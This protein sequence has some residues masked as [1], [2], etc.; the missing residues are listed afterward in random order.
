M[1]K[2]ILLAGL[3][4]LSQPAMAA[5]P[6]RFWNTT[7]ET[8]KTL[9]MAPAGTTAYGP[10]QCA[11]DDDN[12]VDHNERLVLKGITPGRYDVKLGYKNRVCTVRNVEVKGTGRYAFSLDASDL[13]DC[14]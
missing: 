12:E 9:T 3:C 14:Q 2:A 1:R 11:N 4:G 7:N 13:T 6:M 5:D 8:V 10:N